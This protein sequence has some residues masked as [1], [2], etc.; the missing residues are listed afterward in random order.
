MQRD[1]EGGPRFAYD[2]EEVA[3]VNGVNELEGRSKGNG[4]RTC[5]P[6]GLLVLVAQ[7]GRFEAT[8]SSCI[9]AAHE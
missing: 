9:N 4:T 5:Q 8:V 2:E 7:F 6:S 1:D 3:G